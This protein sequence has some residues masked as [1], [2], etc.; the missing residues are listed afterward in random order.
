MQK[1]PN[2][3]DTFHKFRRAVVF[4]NGGEF[5]ARTEEEQYMWSECSRLIAEPSFITTR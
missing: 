3:G 2:S 4:I 5:R 1:A